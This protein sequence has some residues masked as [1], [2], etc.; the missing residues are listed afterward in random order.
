[1]STACLLMLLVSWLRKGD[2]CLLPAAADEVTVS[3][4]KKMK[5]I[6][7]NVHHESSTQSRKSTA[8]AC[9]CIS[10]AALAL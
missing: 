2:S 10:H 6:S 1:M 8:H 9:A 7:F 4:N 3:A 5:G